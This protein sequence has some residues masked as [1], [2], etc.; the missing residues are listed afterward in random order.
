M[1]TVYNYSQCLHEIA[2]HESFCSALPVGKHIRQ[3]C[4]SLYG[5]AGPLYRKQPFSYGY[6][7]GGKRPIPLVQ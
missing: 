6:V 3:H 4:G 2:S 7:G 1:V 5:T